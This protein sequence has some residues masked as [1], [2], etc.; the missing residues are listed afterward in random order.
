M[1]FSNLPV[2]TILEVYI[3]LQ[4][5][6]ALVQ[7]LPTPTEVGGIWYRSIYNFLCII[8]ADFKSFTAKLPLPTGT[9]GASSSQ[10]DQT[11]GV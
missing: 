1:N 4:I 5:S 6:T 10:P 8:V 7:S 2:K 3:A 11:K 9:P